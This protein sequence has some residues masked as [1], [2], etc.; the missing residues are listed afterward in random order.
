MTKDARSRWT[1]G[2]VPQ[3]GYFRPPTEFDSLPHGTIRETITFLS[4]DGAPCQGVLYSKGGERTVLCITHP[5][6][7][8]TRH[9]MTPAFLDAGYAVFGFTHSLRDQ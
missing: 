4:E 6:A 2:P 5:R 9:Y 7:D 3:P 8:L 1:K